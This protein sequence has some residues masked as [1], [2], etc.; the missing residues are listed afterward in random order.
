MGKLAELIFKEFGV[1]T[2]PR[3]NPLVSSVGTSVVKVLNNNP[4][5]I[6]FLIFNLGD[7]SLYIAPDNKVSAS[8]GILVSSS[9]GFLNMIYKEDFELLGHN[10]YG[11]SPSG[12]TAIHVLELIAE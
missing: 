8:Y 3:I 6:A 10:F 4:D 11:V 9:G 2:I 12:I 7:Y 1:K 5:R